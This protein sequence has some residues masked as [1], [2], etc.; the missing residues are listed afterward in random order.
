VAAGMGEGA[1]GRGGCMGKGEEEV[2]VEAATA[3]RGGCVGREKRIGRQACVCVC[4]CV[5]VCVCVC[6]LNVL[7]HGLT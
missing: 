1:W 5:C 4:L 6:M 7:Q 3:V 2:E